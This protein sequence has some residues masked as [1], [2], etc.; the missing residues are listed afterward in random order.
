MVLS[1]VSKRQ[2]ESWLSINLRLPSHRDPVLFC[3]Q[4]ATYSLFLGD[5]HPIYF[6]PKGWDILRTGFIPCSWAC[7]ITAVTNKR[8]VKLVPPHLE[9]GGMG[10]K[11]NK[12]R[13][14]KQHSLSLGSTQIILS[15]RALWILQQT[16]L[17]V[18]HILLVL[19]V[20]P[21]TK[22]EYIQQLN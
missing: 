19:V 22:Q 2:E 5:Y 13:V 17:A 12:V 8:R 7:L 4:P 6:P 14:V 15:L 1:Y 11:A 20:K 9:S 10:K 16:H 18:K 3:P 21:W